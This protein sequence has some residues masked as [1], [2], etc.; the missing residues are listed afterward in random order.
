MQA[1][2]SRWQGV[3]AWSSAD[4]VLRNRAGQ[5]TEEVLQAANKRRVTAVLQLALADGPVL[6]TDGNGVLVKVA[7]ANANSALSFLG[8]AVPV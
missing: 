4:F 5:T 3:Q 7:N 2:S 6:C 1:A 8:L